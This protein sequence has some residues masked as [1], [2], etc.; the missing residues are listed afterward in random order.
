M[1]CYKSVHAACNAKYLTDFKEG[2]MPKGTE[3]MLLLLEIGC[4]GEGTDSII[5][6]GRSDYPNQG[7]GTTGSIHIITTRHS[8]F[9]ALPPVT[10]THPRVRI[11]KVDH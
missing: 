6:T 4:A 8:R 11:M 3:R 1:I 7:K 9:H 5:A 2:G 10:L